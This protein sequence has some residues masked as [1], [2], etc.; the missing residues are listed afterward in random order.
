MTWKP[1][2][3][4]YFLAQILMYTGCSG[5]ASIYASCIA[6][7]ERICGKTYILA[8]DSSK[9][10]DK[11]A[12]GNGKSPYVQDNNGEENLAIIDAP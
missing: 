7:R 6:Y 5:S 4:L 11:F 3:I 12:K 1:D 10:D 9:G 8:L 2:L